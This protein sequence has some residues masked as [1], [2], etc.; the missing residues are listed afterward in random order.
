MESSE[1]SLGGNSHNTSGVQKGPVLEERERGRGEMHECSERGRTHF[2][3]VVCPELRSF[4][5]LSISGGQGGNSF[6]RKRKNTS[7]LPSFLP[8]PFRRGARVKHGR[9]HFDINAFAFMACTLYIHSYTLCRML[10]VVAQGASTVLP[11]ATRAMP[12][13]PD[14]HGAGVIDTL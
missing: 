9:V 13:Y 4:L 10:R 1:K 3:Q 5:P 6:M 8:S 7:Y 11:L 12:Q 2:P 14:Q